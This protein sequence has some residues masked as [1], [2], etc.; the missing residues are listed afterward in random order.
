MSISGN[1]NYIWG[2]ASSVPYVEW[3]EYPCTIEGDGWQVI[4]GRELF[5]QVDVDADYDEVWGVHALGAIFA[6][7]IDGSGDWRSIPFPHGRMLHVSASGRGY[8]WGVNREHEIFKCK[9]PCS[10][11]WKKVA[12]FMTQIDGGHTEVCG[13]DEHYVVW[14][15]PVGGSGA[16]RR[17]PKP[18]K[19]VTTSGSYYIYGISISKDVFRCKKP[20]HGS[21]EE[22]RFSHGLLKGRRLPPLIQ[23]DAAVGALFGVGEDGR[24]QVFRL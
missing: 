8:V 4:P 18:M 14:C 9:K 21:W 16:W 20:C 11:Q 19:Y 24:I 22:G 10:G 17:V 1:L 6:R 15:R 13:V 7:P 23:C 3:C 5:M 12:G 2:A